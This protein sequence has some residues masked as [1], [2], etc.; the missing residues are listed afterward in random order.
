MW[1]PVLT[2]SSQPRY[3]A[4]VDA[5][6]AAIESGELKV[7]DRLPPQRRLAWHLGL[8]PSTTMQAYR[9]AARRHLVSGEVGRGTY[10]LAGSKEAT[11]FRLK[12]PSPSLPCIDLSTHVPALD[13]Y[14]RDL[15]DA[16]STLA[17]T[18]HGFAHQGYL[19]PDRLTQGCIA[20]ANWLALRGMSYSPNQ[21]ML[22]A[23]AQQGVFAALLALCK[24][25][26]PVLAEHLTAPGIKAAARQLRLPLH[27]IPLDAQ[28]P[29]PDALDR[30]VRATGARVVVLIPT[31]QNPTGL[32]MTAERR[33][34]LAEIVHRHA[35][36]I[37]EDDV[38]GA[39]SNEPPLAQVLPKRTLMITSLSKTVAPGLRIGFLAG[40]HSLLE[41]I[42][43]EGQATHWAISPLCLEIAQRWIQDGT[44]SRRLAWQQE[45]VGQRWRLARRLLGTH[46]VTSAQPSPHL[47]MTGTGQGLA[48][49]CRAA[50]VEGVGASTF[51]VTSTTIDAVRFSLSAAP[52]RV[53]LK[54]ALERIASAIS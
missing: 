53:V 33:H 11:L 7:G 5:I 46:W 30:L 37:I 47:W 18:V 51:A 2:P 6:A 20:G 27:G 38:Y 35:L 16:L 14:N 25:G 1:T 13:P 3:L 17:G 12:A 44:A 8:N 34:L 24:P 19:M 15:E 43:P 36:W 10:V 31:L 29:V 54:Q 23:G 39:L 41:R 52:D 9:E 32:S 28:G 22:C 4:L 48:E 49:R 45:E 50:G 21:L 42:D 40:P 26:E